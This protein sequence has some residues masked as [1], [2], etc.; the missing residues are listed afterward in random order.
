[1]IAI[2][3]SSQLAADAI[4]LRK[5][6]YSTPDLEGSKKV[7]EENVCKLCGYQWFS[8]FYGVVP[9]RCPKC[10]SKFWEVGRQRDVPKKNQ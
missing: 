2:Q 10:K 9:V 3:T 7:I 5:R 4:C 1:M 8:R 6:D